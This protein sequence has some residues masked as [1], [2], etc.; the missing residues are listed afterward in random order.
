MA[1]CTHAQIC[2]GKLYDTLER[3]IETYMHLLP[4]IKPSLVTFQKRSQ[5]MLV[6]ALVGSLSHL[7]HQ[8]LPFFLWKSKTLRSL[9][10]LALRHLT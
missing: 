2:E 10:I 4:I 1:L 8:A 5:L 7:D 9:C 3:G 6:T